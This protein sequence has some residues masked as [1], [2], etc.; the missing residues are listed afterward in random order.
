M[1]ARLTI[2]TAAILGAAAG[3]RVGAWFEDPAFT[4]GHW[5]DWR[6]FVA[7]KTVVGALI[8]GLA[9]VEV[10]K[11]A[12]G[13]TRRTGDLFAV[14]IAVGIAIGRIGCFLTGLD[15]QTYG[16]SSSLPWAVDFGDGVRR[17]PVQLYESAFM[18]LL[19]WGLD[20]RERQPHRD[21]DVFR[22]L[23]IG[24]M[25][26]RLVIDALKP[27]VRIVLGLSSLQIMAGATLVYYAYGAIRHRSTG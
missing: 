13:V 11:R 12:V 14:P 9:A 10:T 7:G 3:S 26:W 23:M 1:Q 22:W 24:Y 27:E 19:A 21:G 20:R 6:T 25:G 18:L 4:V 17:H 8:G 5:H 2:V 16:V 15:D